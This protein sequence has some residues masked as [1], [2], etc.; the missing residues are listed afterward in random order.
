MKVSLYDGIQKLFKRKGLMSERTFKA[1]LAKVKTTAHVT[2]DPLTIHI[3]PE[4]ITKF[5]EKLKTA[6]VDYDETIKWLNEHPKAMI[7]F[8]H[9]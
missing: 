2:H 8:Q 1:T 5:G 9:Q 6:G 7:Q 3:R 4:N